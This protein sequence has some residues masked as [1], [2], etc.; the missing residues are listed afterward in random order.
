MSLSSYSR[1]LRL[2]QLT[3]ALVPNSGASL[4]NENA[5]RLLHTS[6]V[7]SDTRFGDGVGDKMVYQTSESDCYKEMPGKSTFTFLNDNTQNFLVD[8]YSSQGF[9]VNQGDAFI[10]GPIVIFNSAVLSWKVRSLFDINERSLALFTLLDPFPELVLIGYGSPLASLTR[11]SRYDDY[12]DDEEEEK[13]YKAIAEE[14]AFNKAA[15]DHIAKVTLAAKAKGL[16]VSFLATEHAITTYNYLVTEDRLVA[17]A[18]I[19]PFKVTVPSD[20]EIMDQAFSVHKTFEN[21][22]PLSTTLTSKDLLFDDNPNKT[23]H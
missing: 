19:P 9:R 23:H 21:V 2:R 12:E 14:Q 16:N 13:R 22:T 10:L 18:A 1:L 3:R 8:A 15:N 5:C 17:C 4:P 11:V 20:E 7:K 6:M